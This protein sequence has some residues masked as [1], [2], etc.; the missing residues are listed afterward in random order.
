[1]TRSAESWVCP[2]ASAANSAANNA[3]DIGILKPSVYQAGQKV[4]NLEDRPIFD[5]SHIGAIKIQVEEHLLHRIAH[6]TEIGQDDAGLFF[7]D[8][9]GVVALLRERPGIALDDHREVH[10]D[11]LADAAR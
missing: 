9:L 2:A 10:G 8:P 6:P 11:R 4:R 3:S 5:S 1:M 7:A